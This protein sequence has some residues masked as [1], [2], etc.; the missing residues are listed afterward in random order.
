MLKM[1]LDTKYKKTNLKEITNK[2]ILKQDE[3][4]LKYSLLNKHEYMFDGTFGIYAGIKY[5]I[6]LLEGA[7]LY[8]TK[9]FSIWKIHREALKI[10]FYRL[11][12]MGVLNSKK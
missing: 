3:Q 1:I 8:H 4:D 9:P 2:K 6:E 7:H 12:N 10:E 11:V 5:K